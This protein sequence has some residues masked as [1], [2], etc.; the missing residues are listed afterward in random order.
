MGEEELNRKIEILAEAYKNLHQ[1]VL[2]MEKGFI[3]RIVS[4]TVQELNHGGRNALQEELVRKLSRRKKELVKQKILEAVAAKEREL[5]DVKYN[6]VDQLHYCSKPTFYRY[7][8]E[9]KASGMIS[10]VKIE[11]K[12][13][14]SLK[15]TTFDA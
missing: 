13:L 4:E 10:F 11:N 3:K 12:R 6:V 9:M 15:Q 1:Y 2:G 5:A 7:I 8:D 14:I